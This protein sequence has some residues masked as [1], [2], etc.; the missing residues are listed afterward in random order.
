MLTHV[1]LYA[2]DFKCP[3]LDC[4]NILNDFGTSYEPKIKKYKVHTGVDFLAPIGTKVK[5]A[6]DGK[7]LKAGKGYNKKLRVIVQHSNSIKS[8]YSYLS[9]INVKEGQLVKQGDLIGYSGRS[10]EFSRP[11]LHFGAYKGKKR[12][13]PKKYF[14]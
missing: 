4:S 3:I 10:S 6:A 2:G 9:K 14:N 13:D 8:I 12:V 7:V 1:S 11:H 5:A